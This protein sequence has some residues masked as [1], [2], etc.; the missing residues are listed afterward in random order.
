MTILNLANAN[1]IGRENHFRNI[2]IV[3]EVYFFRFFSFEPDITTNPPVT[4]LVLLI[5]FDH[6]NV[7]WMP[8]VVCY[9]DQIESAHN[10]TQTSPVTSCQILC[11]EL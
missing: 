2:C 8:I 7:L 5:I 10:H 11:P 9:R 1:G 4:C 3:F 6:F